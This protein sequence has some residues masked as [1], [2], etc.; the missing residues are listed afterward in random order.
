M[1]QK[2]TVGLPK[3]LAAVWLK[4]GQNVYSRQQIEELRGA[5]DEFFAQR[6]PDDFFPLFV[7]IGRKGLQ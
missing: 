5:H 1:I 6:G 2:V 4:L 3:I 7:V